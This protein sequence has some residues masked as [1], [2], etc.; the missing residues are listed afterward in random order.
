MLKINSKEKFAYF[1]I[2]QTYAE[3]L[4]GNQVY[5]REWGR[6]EELLGAKCKRG[7]I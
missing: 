7:E 3:R 6:T 1:Y 4:L 2:Q 5:F